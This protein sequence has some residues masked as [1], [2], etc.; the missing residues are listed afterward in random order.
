MRKDLLL[1]YISHE[2]LFVLEDHC[3]EQTEFISE[4]ILALIEERNF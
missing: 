1:Q 3:T 4:D 2:F